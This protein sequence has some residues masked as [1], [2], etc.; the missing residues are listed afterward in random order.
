MPL[1]PKYELDEYLISDTLEFKDFV[2]QLAFNLHIGTKFRDHMTGD[3]TDETFWG[4]AGNDEIFSYGGNDSVYGGEGNDTVFAGNGNDLVEGGEGDDTIFGEGDD[5]TLNGGDGDDSISGG[6]GNDIINGGAGE[7]KINGGQG[8]D[9]LTGGAKADTF[10]FDHLNGWGKDTI[11]D[12]QDGI[13]MISFEQNPELGPAITFD[14][15]TITQ[16][17]SKA[18]ISYNGSYIYVNGVSAG[19]LTED[20]FVF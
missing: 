13:D 16:M 14:D 19:Q 4:L 17:G 6:D 7:D 1:G 5:D 15:L 20:D 11:T 3:L 18:L 12:F 2:P 10:W 8:N 9:S